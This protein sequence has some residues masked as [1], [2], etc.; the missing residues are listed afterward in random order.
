MTRSVMDRNYRNRNWFSDPVN[1]MHRESIPMYDCGPW[2]T[3]EKTQKIRISFS[4]P[5]FRT[6][7]KQ[8]RPQGPVIVTSSGVW[9]SLVPNGGPVSMQRSSW[10]GWLFHGHFEGNQSRFL[11]PS[12]NRSRTWIGPVHFIPCDQVFPLYPLMYWAGTSDSVSMWHRR[13]WPKNTGDTGTR[14]VKFVPT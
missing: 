12:M 3:E 4:R 1:Q 6:Y 14:C 2:V 13:N 8:H 7:C 10:T 5:L 11:R 9:D